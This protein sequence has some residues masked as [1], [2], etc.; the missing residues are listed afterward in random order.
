MRHAAALFLLAA[1]VPLAGCEGCNETAPVRFLEP[2][3]GS[4][5]PAGVP[6]RVRISSSE[7]PVEFQGERLEG[8]GPWTV[9]VDPVDGLGV[10][11]A[12]VPGNPLIAVRSYH[13]GRYRPPHDFH[14]G[15][16]RLALGPDAVSGGDGTLAA[17][18]GGLLAD[19]E[20]E[21]FVDEPLT[22]SVTVGLPVAVQVYVDSVTTPSAA[23][24]LTPVEGSIDF[25][26]S[27]TD[28]LVDYRATASA[29]N[30]SGTA[31][32]DTM[33]VRGTAT[34]TT[35]AVTLSD[36][37]SEHS[38]PEIV[39][40]GGLPPA[41]VA[42]LATLL[43]DE[44]PEAIAAAA[45]RAANAV[46]VRLLTDLRPT[47]GVAFD[48]PITQR[49]EPDGVAVTAAGLAMTYRARIE[50]ATPAV[51]AADHGVLERAAGP[52][53]DGAGV[54]VGVGSALVNPF[55]FAVWDAG[56]F[57][58]LS[59]SKAELESLG[60]ETL[61]FP[62]SNLQ[63]ADLSLLLPPILEWAPDGPRLEIGGIEIRLTVTGYGETRAWTAASVPVALRQDGANL[64][65]VVDEAR[66]VTLQDAGFEAMS[67]LVDQNKVL[68]LLRTAV[69]GVVGEVFGDLPALELTPIPLT[70]LDGT[71]G[72]VVRPSLSAVA[73]A[74]R[75]WILTVA[76][77]VE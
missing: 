38:D 60:M 69:P 48:H 13:Q 14:A 56:N 43:N 7:T 54:Q 1:V 62:Y 67:T 31:R 5:L 8:S 22:M 70:R 39:D 3:P 75:G 40:A 53:V 20:L 36:V 66:S 77:D 76:L 42:S 68:Q 44:L 16:M 10:L 72:P 59:F 23:V 27:L 4:M 32:Y 45:E 18:V 47:V 51:A 6:V 41:G 34:L 61:E 15:V 52:A 50:A 28:V 71:A 74:D 73:P 58:D 24:A 63:S 25:E 26:A 57:A 9:D 17:L 49:I 12:E 2:P 35:E 30:S 46:V 65:L 64:R 29:L 55:A 37:T 21:S 11:V 19:A 33:T